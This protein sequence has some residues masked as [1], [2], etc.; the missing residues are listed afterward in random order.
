[1]LKTSL[2]LAEFFFACVKSTIPISTRI[3]RVITKRRG[4]IM[5]DCESLVIYT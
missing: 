2:E 1:M 5:I 3:R 4:S